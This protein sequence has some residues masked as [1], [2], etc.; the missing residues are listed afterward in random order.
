MKNVIAI[1]AGPRKNWNTDKLIKAAAEGARLEDAHVEYI[2]LYQLDQFMG[3]RSCFACKL[4]DNYG[5]CVF[6]DGL[7]DV[8]AKIRTA[9]ALI[10]GSPNYLGDLTSGFR[11]LYERLIFQALT[12]NLEEYVYNKHFIPTLL[13]TTSNCSE[14]YYEETGYTK[15]L[16]NYV[17]NFNKFV[18]PTTLFVCGN[19][20]QVSDYSRF[21]WT[22][23]SP[24]E[25]IKHHEETFNDYLDRAKQLGK[26]LIRGI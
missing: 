25:K 9:D 12:Y 21:K 6:R 4:P 2:D 18:G 22:M 8:L 17:D 19:T 10:I 26:Q 15:M 1:N 16:G 11:A 14:D 3:C 23:F 24:E 7:Y 5:K 20:V 13:I